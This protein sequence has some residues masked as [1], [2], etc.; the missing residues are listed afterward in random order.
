MLLARAELN[1]Q[2]MM[3]RLLLTF[4]TPDLSEAACLNDPGF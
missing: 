4:I 1:T 2:T 3:E